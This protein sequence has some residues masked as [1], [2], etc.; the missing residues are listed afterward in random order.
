MVKNNK[1]SVQRGRGRRTRTSVVQA[2]QS[3]RISGAWSKIG[4]E[5]WRAARESG[6]R[7]IVENKE[8]MDDS[9]AE[10]W[11]VAVVQS[12]GAYE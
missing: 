7:R 5:G 6:K 2:E 11:V 9:A 12:T 3:G 1:D 8:D 10:E 4:Q